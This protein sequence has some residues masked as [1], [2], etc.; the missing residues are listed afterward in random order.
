MFGPE[1][2]S[3]RAGVSLAHVRNHHE[4]K[5]SGKKIIRSSPSRVHANSWFFR[6][7]APA[8]LFRRSTGHQRGGAANG[9][10]SLQPLLP[11]AGC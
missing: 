4:T 10:A 7:P 3:R 9:S 2:V 6:K 11:Q 1:F 5:L 8:S